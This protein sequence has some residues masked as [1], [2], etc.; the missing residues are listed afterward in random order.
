MKT[1]RNKL[2]L[3]LFLFCCCCFPAGAQLSFKIDSLSSRC[4]GSIE[5]KSSWESE[6]LYQ[7]GPDILVYGVLTNNSDSPIILDLTEYRR[8][9]DTLILHKD[10]C[11]EFSYH[12]IKDY[13]FTQDPLFSDL[14]SFLC[15]RGLYLPIYPIT[16]NERELAYSIIGAGESIAL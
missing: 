5:C 13:L 3:L 10:L 9:A 7:R 4:Y 6:E 1:T 8:D 2:S 11:F 16:I 14:F 12:Y 15:W